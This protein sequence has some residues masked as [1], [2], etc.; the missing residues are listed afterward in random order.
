EQYR[1]ATGERPQSSVAIVPT[2]VDAARYP[3]HPDTDADGF[4]TL[5]WIGSRST[6]P[7]LEALRPALEDLAQRR[8]QVRLKVICDAFPEFAHIPVI[9]VPWSEATE[10]A[11]V[12]A[13]DIGLMPLSDDQWSR[14]KCG[15]KILQYQ[16]AAL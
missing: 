7:Y 6:L 2:V 15:L 14:G 8:R 5:G 10:A 13:C 11:E 12:A 9:H 4:V 3:L 1:A 16:A